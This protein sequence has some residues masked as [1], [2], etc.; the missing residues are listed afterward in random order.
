MSAT[1]PPGVPFIS[2]EI[3]T[4]RTIPPLSVSSVLRP[5]SWVA[6][7]PAERLRCRSLHKESC[8]KSTT[9]S[10]RSSKGLRLSAYARRLM[11]YSSPSKS[12]GVTDDSLVCC[13][14]VMM[15]DT[16]FVEVDWRAG[17]L[18]E[19]VDPDRRSCGRRYRGVD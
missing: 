6:I 11:L 2:S 8:T 1:D 15:A 7:V 18:S 4:T 5:S 17:Y 13:Q 14:D 12:V 16:C 10:K 3:P 9:R 19:E